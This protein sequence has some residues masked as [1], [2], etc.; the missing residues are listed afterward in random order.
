MRAQGTDPVQSGFGLMEVWINKF[1][2]LDWNYLVGTDSSKGLL[3][4]FPGVLLQE[5]SRADY[6]PLSILLKGRTADGF[7]Y[8]LAASFPKDMQ[9]LGEI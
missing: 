9:I 4:P 8:V 3:P 5:S 1:L 7:M 6:D 2:Q